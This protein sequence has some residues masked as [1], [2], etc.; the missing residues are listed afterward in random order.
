[1]IFPVF[2][3]LAAVLFCVKGG[4]Q[5]YTDEEIKAAEE[6]AVPS[7][8]YGEIKRG[9]KLFNSLSEKSG[10]EE[11]EAKERVLILR[12]FGLKWYYIEREAGKAW[13]KAEE[14]SIPSDSLTSE[15]ALSAEEIEC[16]INT[17]GFK[18]KTDKFIWV[19]IYRQQVYI[20]KG[21]AG[22]FSLEKRIVCGT[23]KNCSPTT[24]GL[25]EISDRGEWFYSERLKSGAKYWVRFNEAYLFHS[26]AMDKEENITDPTLGRRCSSG[27]VRTSVKDAEYIY[28]TI[29][30]G[31][32]VWVN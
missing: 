1:M 29:P 19:D 12:D 9:T 6:K 25:F 17:H 13:V 20:L 11:A 26:V 30:E 24:R 10:F 14:I 7:P 31:T 28:K 27:C 15:D 23:G 18:S 21:S 3:L 32:A 8:V 16:Y 5:A 4:A 2:A 22:G